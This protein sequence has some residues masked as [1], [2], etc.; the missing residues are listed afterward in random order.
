MKPEFAFA[1]ETVIAEG[2]VSRDDIEEIK[3]WAETQT[4][5]PE[6]CDEQIALFLLSCERD[7]EY[8]KGTICA[9]YR[10][11]GNAPELFD[12]RDLDNRR[13]LI[14]QL[15]VLYVKVLCV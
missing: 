3:R 7:R 14:H 9:H 12:G 4:Q 5:L 6:M 15:Q 2:R 11:K 13:D 1:V 10:L 8:T